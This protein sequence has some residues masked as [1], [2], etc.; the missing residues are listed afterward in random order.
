MSFQD[1][2]TDAQFEERIKDYVKI[3]LRDLCDPD[4]RKGGMLR[5]TIDRYD[6]NGD[7]IER[8]YRMGGVL[9]YI[10]LP[11]LR[12]VKCLNP[13]L[14]SSWSVQLQPQQEVLTL[15]YKARPRPQATRMD[16]LMRDMMKQIQEGRF[17]MKRKSRL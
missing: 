11:R 3:T 15:Y 7:F 12:F 16:D 6:D 1:S 5:Y 10:D 17:S 14:H 8:K 13:F 9:T 4:F 2:L